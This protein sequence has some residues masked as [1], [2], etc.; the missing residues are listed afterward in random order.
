MSANFQPASSLNFY[1]YVGCRAVM[2]TASVNTSSECYGIVVRYGDMT[3]LCTKF[4][5]TYGGINS[6]TDI[7]VP[8]FLLVR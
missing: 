1:I 7:V 3:A 8:A 6:V 4:S 5:F 2:I